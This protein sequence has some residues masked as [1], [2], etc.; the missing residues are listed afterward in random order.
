MH[1]VD[2]F[3]RPALEWFSRENGGWLQRPLPTRGEYL[4]RPGGSFPMR[5]VSA[6]LKLKPPYLAV[7]STEDPR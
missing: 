3:D 2:A 7:V 4:I 1:P 5:K 6:V